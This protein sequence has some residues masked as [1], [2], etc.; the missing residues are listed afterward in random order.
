MKQGLDTAITHNVSERQ[1]KREMV[2]AERLYTRAMMW[3][4]NGK[5]SRAGADGAEWRAVSHCDGGHK[6]GDME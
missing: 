2:E 1:V 5:K 4:R 3:G 6:A